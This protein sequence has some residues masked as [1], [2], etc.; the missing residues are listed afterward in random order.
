MASPQMPMLKVTVLH[1][2]D[3][4]HDEETWLKWYNEEQI[5][6]FM[7]VALRNGVDRVEIYFTP[8]AFKAQ[9]QEDLDNLKGGCAEGWNM[10]PY[11]AA[12]IYWTSD[13]QKIRNMLTDPDWEGKVTKFE[14][15]WI[16]QTKV[17]VQIGTQTTFIEDGKIIN[18]T[19][20][21]YPA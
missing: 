12:V 15:G 21:E 3:Q 18:T 17:D 19:P 14:Q 8:T 9:F 20:K 11:D 13:P 6:R 1:Y 4:S 2:R 7:P 10:A 16:D 5:P